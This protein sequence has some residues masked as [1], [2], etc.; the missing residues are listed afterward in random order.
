MK[1]KITLLGFCTLIFLTVA[2]TA[3]KQKEKDKQQKNEQKQSG[4]KNDAKHNKSDKNNNGKDEDRQQG[5]GPGKNDKDERGRDENSNNNG[6][7]N[8]ERNNDKDNQTKDDGYGWNRDTFK[9]RKKARNGDKVTI[10]HKFKNNDEPAV[11]IRVS[12]HAAKAHMNHGDVMGE[13]PTAKDSRY[14]DGYLRNRTDYYNNIG[15][16]QE[17]VLYSRSILDYAVTRLANSRLQLTTLRNNNTPAAEVERKQATVVE[18]EQNV[19]L[20]ETLIGVTAN[21]VAN[22]L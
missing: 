7:G 20:L 17:Q 15:N 8:S 3:F 10:C 13:C 14:S 9:D 12:S 16:S 19:S 1:N 22:K 18:L 6:R 11:A 2:F 21:I 4:G 5:E